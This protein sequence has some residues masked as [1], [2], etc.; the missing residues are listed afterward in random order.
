MFRNLVGSRFYQQ[1]C[2]KARFKTIPQYS[3]Q[4]YAEVPEIIGIAG[5]Q[6]SMSTKQSNIIKQLSVHCR[7]VVDTN[8]VCCW[9][10]L[11]SCILTTYKWATTINCFSAVALPV[12]DM[13]SYF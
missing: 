11:T 8:C 3:P 2:V 9:W 13:T 7:W 6:S 10:V 1:F 5:C 12:A 4:E